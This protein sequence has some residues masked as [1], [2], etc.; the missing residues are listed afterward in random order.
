[1]DA[2]GH[3][4]IAKGRFADV[5][6]HRRRMPD[7]GQAIW[8]SRESEIAVEASWSSSRAQVVEREHQVQRGHVAVDV[9]G[10]SK[11]D[12]KVQI[13]PVIRGTA[14]RDVWLSCRSTISPTRSTSP[15]GKAFNPHVDKT[16]LSKLA[17]RQSRRK[18]CE[19]RGLSGPAA[20]S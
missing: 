18:T 11:T 3:A 2:E 4:Y 1:M 5:K 19:R 13:G 20:A 10:D 7:A 14:L 8:L 17:A 12:A 9:D 15:V 6:R 16:L